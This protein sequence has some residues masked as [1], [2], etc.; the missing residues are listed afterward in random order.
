VAPRARI[1]VTPEDFVVEE[2]PVYEPSGSGE[3]LFLWIEKRDVTTFDAVKRIARAMDVDARAIGVAGLK[4]KV[5]VTRQWV[6]V[7]APAKDTTIESRALAL[8]IDGVRV[9]RAER[10]GNKLKTGHLRGNKFEI[11][12]RGIASEAYGDV[13]ATLARI[14]RDGAPNAFGEQRFGRYGNT[15]EKA[16]EWLTGKAR[17]PRDPR[18]RRF[19]FSALQS[20]IFN[21]VLDARVA[22]GTWTTPIAGDVLKKEESGG[23]FV[24]TDVQA[25]RERASRGEVCPTGPIVGV[26]MKRPEGDVL[27]LEER[28]AAPFIEGID[29]ERARPLGEGTRRALV[30]R[31]HGLSLSEVMDQEQGKGCKVCFVLPKGSYATTVLANAIDV[32]EE[33]P[34]EE[35]MD[36]SE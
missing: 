30:L 17:A 7:P 10:H 26:K 5:A 19:E 12:V 8:A 31:V 25:D 9:L 6:S 16:R 35:R 24:C 36:E 21:A 4:D 18:M 1:K 23:L 27:A 2:I 15:A 20:A 32:S 29:L 11:V 13:V 33:V 3:H 34:D 28:I 14:G 22:E